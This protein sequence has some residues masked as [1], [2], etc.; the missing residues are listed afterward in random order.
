[1]GGFQK[2]TL[3]SIKRVSYNIPI[4][5]EKVITDEQVLRVIAGRQ[6]LDPPNRRLQWTASRLVVVEPGKTMP[7]L[8]LI[9]HAK[10]VEWDAKEYY[11]FWKDKD[12]TNESWENV[13]ITT[14]AGHGGRQRQHRSNPYGFPAGT[15]EYMRAYR[16]ANIQRFRNYQKAHRQKINALVETNK[17]L[18]EKLAQGSPDETVVA[19]GS[20]LLSEL[21]TLAGVREPNQ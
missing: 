16:K 8:E 17:L 3:I 11:A 13:E 5:N 18:Q 1:M 21:R 15:P 10:F 9:A 12:W 19:E 6:L 7:L 20:G 2:L 4:M 14:R